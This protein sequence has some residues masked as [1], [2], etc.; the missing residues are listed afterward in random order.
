MIFDLLQGLDMPPVLYYRAM[1]QVV[2]KENGLLS[3]GEDNSDIRVGR[4]TKKCSNF[5][6]YVEFALRKLGFDSS[7][8]VS[9][10]GKSTTCIHI[11]IVYSYIIYAVFSEE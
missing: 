3:E 6:Q 7:S 5:K 4:M 10:F 8:V 1:L 11:C 2:L 9:F